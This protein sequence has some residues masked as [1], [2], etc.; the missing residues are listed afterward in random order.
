VVGQ[1]LAWFALV[2]LLTYKMRWEEVLLAAKYKGYA[3]Y[4]T[5]VPAIIPGLKR[6]K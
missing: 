1:F 3:E 5:R 6:S 4:M 2:L